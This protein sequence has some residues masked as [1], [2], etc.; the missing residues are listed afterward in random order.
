MLA[1]VP[2]IAQDIELDR[3]TT[4]V[5][6]GTERTC[7]LS[8]DLKPVSQMIRFVIGPAGDAVQFERLGYFCVDK[9]SRTEALVFNRIVPLRDSWAKAQNS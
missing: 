2:D 1:E 4:S 6:P 7:A 8:R 5:A 3:G 9:D